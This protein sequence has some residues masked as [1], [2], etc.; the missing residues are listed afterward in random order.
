M[1][2]LCAADMLTH[3]ADDF[4]FWNFRALIKQPHQHRHLFQLT[5]LKHTYGLIIPEVCTS[6][7]HSLHLLCATYSSSMCLLYW[8]G[9]FFWK[10]AVFSYEQLNICECRDTC[11]HTRAGTHRRWGTQTLWRTDRHTVP[12]ASKVTLYF[13]ERF[14]FF[15]IFLCPWNTS[16]SNVWDSYRSKSGPLCLCCLLKFIFLHNAVLAFGLRMSEFE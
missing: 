7:H 15:L 14:N 16:A 1:K 11:A 3:P 6:P 2:P 9:Y 5:A 10:A 12:S 4:L 8:S 13:C